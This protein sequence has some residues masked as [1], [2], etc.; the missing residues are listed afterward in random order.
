MLIHG[1][2]EW[3]DYRVSAD[4]TPHLSRVAGLAARVQGLRRYY[5]LLLVPGALRLVKMLDEERILAEAPF[6]WTFGERHELSLEVV[7]GRIRASVDGT[8]V[9]DIV[10]D[11]RPLRDGAV[12]LVV[13]EGRTATRVVRIQPAEEA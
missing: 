12:A 2:R 5:A 10:D 13:E 6:D 8:P 11:D 7:K 9:F 1:T 3:R 4:V